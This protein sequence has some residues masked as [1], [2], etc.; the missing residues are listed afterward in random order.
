MEPFQSAV[1][2]TTANAVSVVPSTTSDNKVKWRNLQFW[3]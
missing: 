3:M 2:A 1:Q